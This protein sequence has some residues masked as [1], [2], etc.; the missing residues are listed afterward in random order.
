MTTI[1]VFTAY[2]P[3]GGERI[4][5]AA[6]SMK[7][8]EK[9]LRKRFPHMRQ[10]GFNRYILDKKTASRFGDGKPLLGGVHE[11]ELYD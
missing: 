3:F 8:G 11:T 9:E 1:Y 10:D 6:K 4:L 7:A 2:S 5:F